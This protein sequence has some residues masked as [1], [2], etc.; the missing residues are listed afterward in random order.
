V[1]IIDKSL[2]V[3]FDVIIGTV[4]IIDAVPDFPKKLGTER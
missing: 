1:L 3:A 4:V 2:E